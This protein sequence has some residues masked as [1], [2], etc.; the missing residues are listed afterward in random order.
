MKLVH[1]LCLVL[2]LM[3]T[4][5]SGNDDSFDPEDSDFNRDLLGT[6][7]AVDVQFTYD[8]VTNFSG[9]DIT[10][11]AVGQ[12]YDIN[13][14]IIFDDNPNET[15]S[16]GSY[17]LEVT[18]TTLGQSE[19]E[20]IENIMFLESGAWAL[21]G[22]ELIFADSSETGTVEIFEL[23]AESLIIGITESIN[24]SEAGFNFSSTS[25]STVT[26]VKQVED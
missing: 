9:Q 6:W 4:A 10:S 13:F 11:Q 18:T 12:G 2:A 3:L 1:K 21:D 7:I 17:S 16:D 26:F 23:T 15:I 8:V 14:T 5:C 20:N 25:V 19:V 24:S 22:D